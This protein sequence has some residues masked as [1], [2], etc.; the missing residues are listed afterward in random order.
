[1]AKKT[2]QK[3]SGV[4]LG[5]AALAAAGAAAA[6]GY[7]FYASENA[8]KNRKIAAKWAGDLKRDVVKEAKKLKKIDRAAI[9][10]VVD[11]AAKTYAANAPR[12]DKQALLRAAKEL[13]AHWDE[14]RSEAG[15][16]AK[17]AKKSA[18]KVVK[19]AVKKVTK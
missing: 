8:P 1:M 18:K 2:V 11:D 17:S 16:V 7:Y 13:K 6:A 9:M 12:I 14:V 10:K 19:R 5:L 15:G 3:G 4:G